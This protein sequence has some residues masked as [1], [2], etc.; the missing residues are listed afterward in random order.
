MISNYP[1]TLKYAIDDWVY[2]YGIYTA[3]QG[4]AY[5]SGFYNERSNGICK[6]VQ[7]TGW[8]TVITEANGKPVQ[9]DFYTVKEKLGYE[10]EVFPTF[11]EV[12]VPIFASTEIE[13]PAH[14]IFSSKNHLIS[15]I[16]G[17]Y[18]NSAFGDLEENGNLFFSKMG[19]LAGGINANG[20]WIDWAGMNFKDMDF[21]EATFNGSWLGG[22]VGSQPSG[23]KTLVLDRTNFQGATMK[24]GYTTRSTFRSSIYS[25]DAE[26]TLFIDGLPIGRPVTGTTAGSISGSTITGTGT[27]F[28]SALSIGDRIVIGDIGIFNITA[29]G[30]NTSLT[31]AETF[32]ANFTTKTISRL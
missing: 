20:D 12:E 21:A 25:Y 18:I 8:R 4:F 3:P 1:K 16:K 15:T 6:S 29:I 30:S 26:T 9:T 24:S 28:L 19:N 11:P 17:N 5:P 23:T 7:I 2:I 32:T 14:K 13:L 31:V 10:S 27:S 22:F